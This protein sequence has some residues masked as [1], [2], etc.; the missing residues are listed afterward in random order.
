MQCIFALHHCDSNVILLEPVC[1]R[2]A[3]TLLAAYEKIHKCLTKAGCCPKLQR[4]DNEASNILTDFMEEKDV[5]YQFVPPHDH[6]R[7]AAE[8]AI[9]TAKCHLIAGWCSTHKD[10]PMYLWSHTIHHA[11]HTLNLLRGSRMNPKLSAWEQ[12]EG[13]YD[14]NATPIAPPGTKYLAHTKT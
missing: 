10:F 8:R 9:R 11:K 14:Y 13:R 6:R 4:L 1:N 12:I 2:K 3:E 7:N 5:K